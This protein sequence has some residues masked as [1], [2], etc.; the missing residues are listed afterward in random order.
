MNIK[1]ET[2]DISGLVESYEKHLENIFSN[3]KKDEK[4]L[5]L[6]ARQ[7][8]KRKL[9]FLLFVVFFSLLLIQYGIGLKSYSFEQIQKT[10]KKFS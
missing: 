5:T 6:H 1:L 3:T 7:A 4:S 9:Q 10:E 8:K 2:I